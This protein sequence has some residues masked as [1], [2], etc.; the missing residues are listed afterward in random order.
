MPLLDGFGASTGYA[1]A[2]MPKRKQ[3]A[4]PS[5]REDGGGNAASKTQRHAKV[6]AAAADQ[7]AT[8]R[9]RHV[10][11]EQFIVGGDANVADVS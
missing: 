11:W 4:G 1:A 10:K 6:P 9:A 3:G 5:S 8:P 2:G 7:K